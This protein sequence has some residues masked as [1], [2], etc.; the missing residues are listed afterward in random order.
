MAPPI[1]PPAEP[2][3]LPNVPAGPLALGLDEIGVPQTLAKA[4]AGKEVW[5]KRDPVLHQAVLVIEEVN[6]G[7]TDDSSAALL[8]VYPQRAGLGRV[9][10][11]DAGLAPGREQVGDPLALTGPPGHGRG[12]AV[13]EIVRVRRH[14]DGPVP[15]FR[16]RLYAP[17][18]LPVG[19][20]V[21]LSHRDLR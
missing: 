8:L 15:V 9:H 7:D 12:D 2:A 21:T 4:L 17:P 5:L 3:K 18:L 16:H 13:L 11:V 6:L 14:G 10:A 19:V 1:E 20:G